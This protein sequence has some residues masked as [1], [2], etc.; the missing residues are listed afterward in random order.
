[1]QGGRTSKRG[2]QPGEGA[3]ARSFSSLRVYNYR[4]YFFGLLVSLTG[5]WMQRLAQAWLVLRITNSALSL[6]TVAMLQ[7]LPITLFSLFGGVAADRIPKRRLLITTQSLTAVQAVLLAVLTA[8]GTIQLWHIYALAALLGLITA[9]DSPAQQAFAMEL[10]GREDVGNA[11]ALTSTTNNATRI[12]GPSLAGITIATLGITG[13]FWLNAA[14]FLAMLGG[15]LAMRPS[16]FYEVPARQRASTVRLLREGID[17]A[18]RTPGV[19]VLFLS[20]AFFGTF[21]F[22]FAVMLP[23]I[24]RYTLHTGSF[25]YGLL[26]AAFGLGSLV[27]GLGLAYTRAQS[28][29]S[30][31]WGGAALATTLAALSLSR[32]LPLSL[33]LLALTGISAVLYSTSTQTRLQVIVPDKLRGRTMSMFSF[34]MMGS[35]AFSNLFVGAVA[36]RWNPQV[37]LM[38][39]AVL[40]AMGLLAAWLYARGKTAAD[41]VRGTSLAGDQLRTSPAVT[42][43]AAAPQGSGD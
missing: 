9:F 31:F 6:G 21:A 29:R 7:F 1:M 20:L 19:W 2:T 3:L 43:M 40:S 12:V 34:C 27:A 18:V 10:V 22:N 11:I 26:F 36:Q 30:V 42:D 28:Q 17:Y 5:T 8:S 35:N 16:Q 25:G 15:L 38:A 33:V 37:S 14:G 41:M 13:C 4:L 39:M 23:L 24:A 32:N